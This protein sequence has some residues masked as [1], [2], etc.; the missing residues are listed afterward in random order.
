[1]TRI[2]GTALLATAATSVVFLSACGDGADPTPVFAP[3]PTEAPDAATD[4]DDGDSAAVLL[5]AKQLQ[6]LGTVVADGNGMTLY[7]FDKDTAQPSVS[8]CDG[9]CLNLWPPVRANASDVHVSGIDKALVGTVTRKDGSS[10]L[11]LRGWPLYRYAKDTAAGDVRGQGV[12]QYWYAIT[13]K[14][15]KA[16]SATEPADDAGYGSG[17]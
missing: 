2:R 1:M 8:N 3:A 9:P 10:Q 4:R 15:A 17:Y 13:P 12:G 5:A 16:T 6:Q 11:T 14:G 7:R